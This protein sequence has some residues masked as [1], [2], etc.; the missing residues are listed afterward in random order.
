M[1]QDSG[2]AVPLRLLALL[3][4]TA[5]AAIVVLRLPAVP[6]D[7][8]YHRFADDRSWLGIPNFQNVAS[9][10]PFLVVGALGLARLRRRLAE[11]GM[12]PPSPRREPGSSSSWASPPR[13]SAPPGT[14]G[15]RRT[16]P[17]SGTAFP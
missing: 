15:R 3:A 10:L 7:P 13:R 14:T 12:R 1:R 5:V 11:A 9:N 6:Q 4:V 16:T 8:A 17:C 2:S